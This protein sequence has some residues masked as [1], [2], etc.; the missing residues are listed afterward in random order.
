MMKIVLA[1]RTIGIEFEHPKVKK[2]VHVKGG[3]HPVVMIRRASVCSIYE[4][5]P[6][7]PPK[8]I[9][10]SICNVHHDDQFSRETGRK[11]GLAR[12]LKF[13]NLSKFERTQVWETYHNR[14]IESLV[15]ELEAKKRREIVGFFDTPEIGEKQVH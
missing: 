8:R 6:K 13:T 1:D 14:G 5:D 2:P 12:A 3:T 7:A 10:H 15:L 4:L 11:L 9:S